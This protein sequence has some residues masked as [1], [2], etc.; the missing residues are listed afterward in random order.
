MVSKALVAVRTT[1][2]VLGGVL[3]ITGPYSDDSRV[4]RRLEKELMH[5]GQVMKEKK[6]IGGFVGYIE[7][8][9]QSEGLGTSPRRRF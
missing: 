3:S 7:L 4:H 8:Q 6:L 2:N 5:L 1:P 9:D